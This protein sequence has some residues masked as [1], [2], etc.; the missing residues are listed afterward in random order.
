MKL[1]F[2]PGILV[3]AAF[4]GP[5]T[6]T[7]CTLAGANFG[8]ALVWALVFAS[9]RQIPAQT[10]SLR[11]G[12]WQMG[13]G[14]SLRGR[15]L[16]LYGY[17]RIARQV[18]AY[19]AA[20]DMNVV[21][22]A[23]EEGRARAAAD[24]CTVAASREAFFAEP[25]VVSIHV[26]LKPAT[27]GLV[28][29]ADLAAMRPDALFVNTSRAGLVAPGALFEALKAGRPGG[30]ALDVF[31]REPVTD[32]NDPLLAMPNVLATPHIGYVTEDELQL[33]FSD[34]FDQIVAFAAGSPIN[35]INPE[36]WRT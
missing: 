30:A 24:G 33:Q 23:S 15:T 4:I 13:V 31:D 16:G 28:T 29:G 5:G 6:V 18:A 26:R 11:S 27:T 10:A 22:W 17:G 14:R 2:G 25:D 35:M 34:I 12:D 8:F 20:F 3:A 36:V 9:M 7:A 32:P 1:D 19:A 21:W